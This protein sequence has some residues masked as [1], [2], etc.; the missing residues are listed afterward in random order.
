MKLVSHMINVITEERTV[1]LSPGINLS[2]FA[3]L[4][5]TFLDNQRMDHNAMKARPI[6]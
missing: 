3:S 2:K 1:E 5:Y 4:N 6:L